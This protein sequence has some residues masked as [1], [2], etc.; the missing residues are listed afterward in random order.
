MPV[1]E[2]TNPMLTEYVI[3]VIVDVDALRFEAI[4]L[5]WVYD[6]IT[7]FTAVRFSTSIV[8][9]ESTAAYIVDIEDQLELSVGNVA[10]FATKLLSCI[11][12]GGP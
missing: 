4:R 8:V 12:Y 5:F 7:K 10:L 3:V 6:G 2:L 1:T 9:T 11:A